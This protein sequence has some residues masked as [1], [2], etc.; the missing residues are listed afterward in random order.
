MIIIM[1]SSQVFDT[2][3]SSDKSFRFK[4]GAG[5]VIKGWDEGMVGMCKGS[6]RVLI[7]PSSM[8]YGSQ[9]VSGRIPPNAPL[10]FDVEV[11]KTKHAKEKRVEPGIATPPKM[12]TPPIDRKSESIRE[13][14]QS[15]EDSLT[16][17]P[18][19]AGND[20]RSEILSRISKM[21]QQM[22]PVNIKESN[23]PPQETTPPAANVPESVP[24]SSQPVNVQP[25]Q[26]PAPQATPI[27]APPINQPL[28]SQV[29]YQAPPIVTSQFAPPPPTMNTQLALY[30][31]PPFHQ[32]G[33]TPFNQHGPP[34]YAQQTPTSYNIYGQPIVTPPVAPP[35]APPPAPPTADT[36]SS[37]TVLLSETKH[38]T[39]EVRLE[40]SKLVSKIEDI[41]GKIDK[42]RE[43]GSGMG[44]ALVSRGPT[45]TM[46]TS[47]LLHNIQRIIQVRNGCHDN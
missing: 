9:G 46:E 10:L 21:G 33:Q 13:R 30:Q 16:D 29:P 19:G 18:A 1:T 35:P 25:A 6:R 34:G 2:N 40:M 31:T 15:L 45:P 20:E 8:A 3:V 24:S 28:Y 23:P 7:I 26:V 47:V 36:S 5:K 14:T 41:S 44:G 12:D 17:I 43:E 4:I 39:T 38:Q 27:Q 42:L 32:Y 22:L 11:R 37:N